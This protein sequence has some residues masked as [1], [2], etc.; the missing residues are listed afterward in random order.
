MCL[1]D[2]MRFPD[3]EQKDWAKHVDQCCTVCEQRR[4]DTKTS[5]SGAVTI[6]PRKVMHWF[7]L[8]NVIRDRLFTDPGF[9]KLRRG[10]KREQ[11]FYPSPEADRLHSKAKC[12]KDDRTIAVYEVGVDAGQMFV[13]K[14]H[15]C[16]FIMVR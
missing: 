7:G 1:N 16:Y 14:V 8:G 12:S 3:L 11:Y 13:N 5:A 6:T 15:S 2:C 9:C 10:N 4:F